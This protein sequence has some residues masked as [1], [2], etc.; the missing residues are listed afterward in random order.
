M[1]MLLVHGC[2]LRGKMFNI[3]QNANVM[4]RMKQ[5]TI[6]LGRNNVVV[7]GVNGRKMFENC[8]LKK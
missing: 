8:V 5:R 2:V 7:N 6:M 1:K 3:E 4:L